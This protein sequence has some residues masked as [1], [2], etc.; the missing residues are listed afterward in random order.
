M[1]DLLSRKSLEMSEMCTGVP[2]PESEYSVSKEQPR[3]KEWLDV[4]FGKQQKG[5]KN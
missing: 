1:D 5:N 4:R 3:R 2:T